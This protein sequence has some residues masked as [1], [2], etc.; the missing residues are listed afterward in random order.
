MFRALILVRNLESRA[1]RL[2]F[3]DF[4]IEPVGLRFQELRETFSSADVNQDDWIFEKSYTVPPSGPPG[5]PVGGIPNDIEDILILFRLYKVGDIAFVNQ[6]IIQPS[7]NRV[8]Q[9]PYRAMNN[10]NSYSAMRFQFGLDECEPWKNFAN[11]LRGSQSWRSEWFRVAR[12]FFLYGG[13]KEFNPTWDDV[14]RIVDYA[15]ALEAAVVPESELSSKRFRHRAA[16]LV[17]PIDLAEQEVVRKLVKQVYDIRSS[18]VHGSKL[19]SDSRDWL[20]KN[21]GELELRVRQVLTAAVRKVPAAEVERRDMLLA[22]YDPA[23]E[24]RGDFA[25]QKFQEIRTDTVRKKTAEKIGRLF[26][27]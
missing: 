3:G 11:G 18:I 7:G 10:L 26:K 24:D 4:T 15:T 19:S 2:D 12:R 17:C 27:G 21:W 16:M 25:V 14:D 13:A 20:I 5:S 22:L 23:D 1:A 9:F 8:V 6:A